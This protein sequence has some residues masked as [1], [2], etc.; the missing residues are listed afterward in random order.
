MSEVIVKIHKY[1]NNYW[2]I[3][4]VSKKESSVDPDKGFFSRREYALQCAQD[5]CEKL[6]YRI[7]KII[8]ELT[9]AED[10]D[11]DLVNRLGAKPQ[12]VSKGPKTFKDKFVCPKCGDVTFL[13]R[14]LTSVGK[15]VETRCSH[16]H[17]KTTTKVDSQDLK[18]EVQ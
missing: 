6:G 7:G 3:I 16:C 12:T 11:E 5:C 9:D 10:A 15:K 1:G 8:D 4:W 13:T 2:P 14:L 17:R 18:L